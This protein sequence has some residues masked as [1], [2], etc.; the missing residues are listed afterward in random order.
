MKVKSLLFSVLLVF[1][2]K[3][4]YTPSGNALPNGIKDQAYS[5]TIDVALPTLAEVG[6]SQVTSL[7]IAAFP[8]AQAYQ[9]A[10]SGMTF[11]LLNLSSQ[12]SVSGLPNGITSSCSPSDC[13]FSGGSNGSIF[14]SGIPTVGG[15]FNVVITSNTFGTLDLS[16]LTA[17]SGGLIPNSL[18]V[19][20]ALTGV[21]DKNYT[22]FILDL[23]D[24][25]DLGLD[26][27]SGMTLYPNPSNSLCQ[28]K[29]F[30]HDDLSGQISIADI[31]GRIVH[32][33][34][35]AIQTGWNERS[36]ELNFESGLYYVTVQNPKLAHSVKLLIHR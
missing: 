14:L 21:F 20:Q 31:N 5:Q 15:N 6:G 24:L 17:M 4:Q 34:D 1:S 28:L 32:I 29:F 27:S 25:D 8:P 23:N 26:F 10:I 9:S 7:I 12:H 33:D 18:A 30:S 2:G 36:L 3:A 11:P 35:I 16:A 22:L 19:S 13:S